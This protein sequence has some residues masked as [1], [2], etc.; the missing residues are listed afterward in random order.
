MSLYKK[1]IL[2]NKLSE[3]NWVNVMA[4]EIK[5]HLNYFIEILCKG[6][7]RNIDTN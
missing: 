1:I 4:R 3:H 2:I 5:Y 7:N 6:E